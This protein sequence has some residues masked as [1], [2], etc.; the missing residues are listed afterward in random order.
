MRF[1][2]VDGLVQK[3]RRFI[4]KPTTVQDEEVKDATK[5]ANILRGALQRIADLEARVPPES[6]EFELALE[7][8]WPTFETKLLAH[9]FNGPVRWWVTC[10]TRPQYQ[11][12]YPDFAPIIVQ[13][14]SSDA[15]TLVL[16]AY[17]IGRV[18]VRVEPANGTME[19]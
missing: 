9:N 7:G 10:W 16:Q 1:V 3:A 17:V 11:A 2:G 13:D 19:P 5:L 15:N 14:A 12:A 8:V 6:V 18:V 4:A